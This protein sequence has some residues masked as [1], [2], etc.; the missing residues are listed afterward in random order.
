MVN[1]VTAAL[2]ISRPTDHADDLI[3][4]ADSAITPAKRILD[5][6]DKSAPLKL[7]AETTPTQVRAGLIGAGAS[8]VS[9]GVGALV[10]A[11]SLAWLTKEVHHISN[12][13]ER[14]AKTQEELLDVTRHRLRVETEQ[15]KVEQQRLALDYARL[16][17][18]KHIETDKARKE[19]I[20]ECKDPDR[21][22]I[23]SDHTLAYGTT[24]GKVLIWQDSRVL[25]APH[26]CIMSSL[27]SAA[28][29][30]VLITCQYLEGAASI[31]EHG[32]LLHLDECSKIAPDAIWPQ[33]QATNHH[34]LR[35]SGVSIIKAMPVPASQPQPLVAPPPPPAPS[36]LSAAAAAAA[37]SAL[38]P[39]NYL[40]ECGGQRQLQYLW[41]DVCVIAFSSIAPLVPPV[42]ATR[43]KH[44]RLQHV[45][46]H[47]VQLL[48]N[49][50]G[51]CEHL[52]IEDVVVTL[53]DSNQPFMDVVGV[54]TVA[55]LDLEVSTNNWG[56]VKGSKLAVVIDPHIR[57]LQAEGSS[58]R[59]AA[60]TPV[61][62]SDAD[63][64]RFELEDVDDV[65]FRNSAHQYTRSRQF[66]SFQIPHGKLQPTLVSEW[67]A[68]H[69]QGTL[70]VDR[71]NYRTLS[72]PAS[73]HG[74]MFTWWSG[75]LTKDVE[76]EVYIHEKDN[77]NTV[78][79]LLPFARKQ[80]HTYTDL[81]SKW[82]F[83]THRECT[84]VLHWNNS[85]SWFNH[86]TISWGIALYE[87]PTWHLSDGTVKISSF[88]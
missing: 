85:Y 31:L 16:R 75:S 76:L 52:H 62:N 86:K 9:M 57:C 33:S 69:R 58:N 10:G 54:D 3:R 6:I 50:A 8:V 81:D 36:N 84:L 40:I 80:Y 32:T 30:H 48:L 46:L 13:M 19:A 79:R 15:L 63:N 38:Q 83:F 61:G 68:V 1:V 26:L 43:V 4:H 12:I 64:W 77:N 74:H 59:T 39:T 25:S 66:G 17:F 28:P 87:G 44:I 29:Q 65:H 78:K 49:K 24:S 22:Y 67:Y 56:T 71:D 45:R 5:T 2:G 7:L 35:I 14:Q 20:R 70:T 34:L 18:E 47:N 60:G 41:L 37:G 82:G 72:C 55:L 73:S 27:H 11:T 51:M 53:D 42:L 23:V 88:L 21:V